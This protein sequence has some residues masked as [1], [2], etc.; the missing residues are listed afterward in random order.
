MGTRGSSGFIYKDT[1][2]LNYNHYDS[3]P[4]GLGRD[5]LHFIV[6]VNKE[7]GWDKFKE[8]SNDIIPI[9][10]KRITDPDIIEKYKKYADLSVSTKTYDDPYCLF[11]KIQ[12]SWMPEIL[13]GELKHFTFNDNFIKESLFCEYAYVINLDTMKLEFYDGYQ[14]ESQ[15]SNRFGEIPNEDGYYPCRLVAV[16]DLQKI[17]NS[18]DV[19]HIV[20]KMDLICDLKKDDPSI[21]Q[22]FRKPKLDKINEKASL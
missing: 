11:R 9:T 20:E 12:D 18:T 6:D 17:Q 7:N 15:P 21:L 13:K 3:Y 10:E 5:V 22:Y 16:F 4:D 2:Y 1:P 14:K 8:N 19:G